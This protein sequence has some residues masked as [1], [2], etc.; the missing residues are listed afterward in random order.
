MLDS[1]LELKRTVDRLRDPGGCE[2]DRAQ[3]FQTMRA[4]LLEEVHEV[5]GAIHTEDFE[6]LSEELGDVLFLVFFLARLGEE[7]ERFDLAAIAG[8]INAKLIRRH[9]HVFADA[10]VKDQAEILENW[11]K[12]K[13]TEKGPAA[14][15]NDPVGEIRKKTNFLTALQRAQKIG[16]LAGRSGL[17]WSSAPAVLEKVREEE[18][19]LAGAMEESTNIEEELGDL[20]FSLTQLARHLGLDAEA[21]LHRASDKFLTRYGAWNVLR[22]K[23]PDLDVDEAWNVARQSQ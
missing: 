5:L 7:T 2:W 16:M 23:N 18:R 1:L 10:V 8:G 4:Y 13:A 17:D 21:A 11:E 22:Q 14:A 20:L 15:Q 9:P 19:E 3:N 6:A 12:I